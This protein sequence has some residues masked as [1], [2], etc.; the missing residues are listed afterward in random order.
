MKLKK[1][2]AKLYS[3][4]YNIW[5]LENYESIYEGELRNFIGLYSENVLMNKKISGFYF[6]R[7]CG[8]DKIVIHLEVK[9][10]NN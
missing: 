4:N 8:I 10:A 2:I 9:N 1:F 6:C 3:Y 5:I 7:T